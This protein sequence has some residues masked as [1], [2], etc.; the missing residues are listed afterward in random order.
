MEGHN[1]IH[2]PRVEMKKL[3]KLYG[4]EIPKQKKQCQ[5][6]STTARKLYSVKLHKYVFW[7]CKGTI[8]SERKIFNFEQF[9]LHSI[10]TVQSIIIYLPICKN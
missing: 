3:S 4:I 5:S 9:R 8:I 2:D 6:G 7:F 10:T 1:H